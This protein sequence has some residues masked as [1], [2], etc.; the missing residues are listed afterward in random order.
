M[1]SEKYLGWERGKRAKTRRE[2]THRCWSQGW[3][4]V[5]GGDV[6]QTRVTQ[7]PGVRP[8][9]ELQL[10]V[11]GGGFAYTFLQRKCKGRREEQGCTGMTGPV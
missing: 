4:W 10:R 3:V 2:K 11:T 5:E 6:E 8:G 7:V 1:K 9:L